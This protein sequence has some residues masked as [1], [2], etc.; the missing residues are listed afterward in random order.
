MSR[1]FQTLKPHVSRLLILAA[2]SGILIL[3]PALSNARAGGGEGFGGGGGGVGGGG[4]GEA[5]IYLLYFLVRLAIEYPP[6]GVP[7]L[8][9]VIIVL[10]VSGLRGAKGAGNT[11]QNRVIRKA[12]RLASG[13]KI[14]AGIDRIRETDI[15]FD[16]AVFVRRTRNAFLAVQKAWSEQ[17]MEKARA[18]V[19]DGLFERFTLQIQEQKDLNYRNR[20]DDVRIVDA[21]V[22]DIAPGEPFDAVT[23]MIRASAHDYRVSLK[24]GKKLP[25]NE[26]H[27]VFVE[28]W[29]FVRRPGVKT[30]ANK[31]GLIEGQCPNCGSPIEMNQ[32][33]KCTSCG[34]LLRS[35]QYDWVLTE[36][37]QAAEWIPHR[38][39][40]S[41][42]VMEYRQNHDPGFHVRHLEDR[43][44][45]MFWR[46]AMADR[47]GNTAPLTKLSTSGF[48][49]KYAMRLRTRNDRGRSY[50][51]DCAVGSVNVPG[52]RPGEQKDLALVEIRW[53]SREF[54]ELENGERKAFGDKRIT[55]DVFLL[56][57]GAGAKT[58]V[59][60]SVSSAHC[61]SCGAPAD[62]NAAE[63]CAYCGALVNNGDTEWLLADILPPYAPEIQSLRKEATAARAKPPVIPIGGGESREALITTGAAAG[64]VLPWIVKTVVAD[65]VVDKS[66]RKLIEGLA[67]KRGVHP[68]QIDA[69]ISLAQ[70]GEMDLPEPRDREEAQ[71]WLETMT[72]TAL[73]DG[74]VSGAEK[75]L[76][77]QA[78]RRVGM[79]DYDVK[80]LITK[81]RKL[82]YQEAKRE[83]K[84][85]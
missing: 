17:A 8:I 61:P 44:S 40:E 50:R 28:Y 37:T 55:T 58:N 85:H 68:A 26:Y 53:S 6:V 30:I 10:V 77:L 78:G 59:E 60:S 23:V 64:T 13:K 71:Q 73:M 46:K 54:A 84:A 75:K 1:Q 69:L 57:R 22:A 49:E 65:S 72:D 19:S 41:R 14:Q 16:P 42:T 63:T 80:Q 32:T 29:T 51:G 67:K 70:S 21:A 62:N 48:T 79:I 39:E 11:Y 7:L 82:L 66:E 15:E 74:K 52:I 35:G 20:M 33:V 4:E 5:I 56:E 76:L 38:E 81:R 18:F 45:V 31:P 47:Q 3:I 36:I 83:L 12:A 24:D 2:V 25:Q 9:I 27:D 34:S 43:A